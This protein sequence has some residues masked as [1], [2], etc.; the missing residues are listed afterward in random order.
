MTQHTDKELELQ[1]PEPVAAAIAPTEGER[2]DDGGFAAPVQESNSSK[3]VE[4]QIEPADDDDDDD[5]TQDGEKAVRPTLAQTR[6]H[7]TTVSIATSTGSVTKQKRPW[8]KNLNP[9]RLGAIPP[10]PK[11][12]I[13]SREAKAGFWSK[14]TF[15]WMGPLMTVSRVSFPRSA[16][17]P[18][19]IG[20]RHVSVYWV[21]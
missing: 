11:E 2:R 21:V 20:A 19:G 18:R 14:L 4:E 3:R 12:P 9:L 5:T 10:I 13:V 16:V 8:Y 15:T 7:A 6:S 17:R 1:A